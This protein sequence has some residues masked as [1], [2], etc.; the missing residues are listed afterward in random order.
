MMSLS[1]ELI[2]VCL[3]VGIGKASSLFGMYIRVMHWCSFNKN[4]ILHLNTS[5]GTFIFVVLF[6]QRWKSP[7]L[8]DRD[9]FVLNGKDSRHFLSH[10]Y[11]LLYSLHPSDIQKLIQKWE[12]DLGE[13]FI[14][15]DWHE[16]IV[17]AKTTEKPNISYS[18]DPTWHHAS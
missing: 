1:Q 17:S 10:S 14:E 18:I 4:K 2:I 15:D 9:S 6:C 13:Q 12:H 16:A 8:S 3:I 5:M 11:S 7:S